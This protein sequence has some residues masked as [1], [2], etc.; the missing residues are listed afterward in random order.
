MRSVLNHSFYLSKYFTI[1]M[2]DS[3]WREE[4]A[5]TFEVKKNVVHGDY[6]T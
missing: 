5:S 6:L 2:Y 1:C 3:Y 4:K